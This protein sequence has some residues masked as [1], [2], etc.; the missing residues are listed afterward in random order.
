MKKTSKRYLVAWG[1]DYDIEPSR[2]KYLIGQEKSV[3]LIFDKNGG[4]AGVE[5]FSDRIEAEKSLNE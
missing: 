4:L 3:V 5:V 2:G 1:F